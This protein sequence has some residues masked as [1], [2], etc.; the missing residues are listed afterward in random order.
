M[1]HRPRTLR[2]KSA[3]AWLMLAATSLLGAC[4]SSD[5]AFDPAVIPDGF[6]K[7]QC[8]SLDPSL[9]SL[10]W[11]SSLYLR[12]DEAAPSGYALQFGEAS[13]PANSG[14]VPL[15]PSLFAGLDGY[16]LGTPIIVGFGDLDVADLPSEWGGLESSIS[17]D[18][19]SILL[20][21]GEDG[22][23]PV[24]HFVERDGR[25]EPETAVAYLRPAE[26][27]AP[28]TRYIVAF[29]DLKDTTGAPIAP[30]EGFL[31][32]RDRVPSHDPGVASRRERFE[33]VF[34][35]LEAHG[36][37]R[38]ELVLAWDFTTGSL[39]RLQGRLDEALA[40]AL[41]DAPEGGALETVTVYPKEPGEPATATENPHIRYSIDATMTAPAVVSPPEPGGAFRVQLDGEGRVATSGA[42]TTKVLI[43]VPHA[44]TAGSPMGV[45]VY[46]HGMFGSEWEIYADH[47]ELLADQYGYVLVAVPMVGM[48]SDD[49]DGVTTAV[50]NMNHFTL[51]TDGLIQ[52]LLN[53]HMLARAVKSGAL[54]ELLAEVDP[55]IEID[56]AELHYF[57]GSQGGIYG[58][59]FLATSPDVH[60]G[61]LAVPGN[62]YATLLSRSVNFNVFFDVLKFAYP[63]DANVATLIAAA[64][65]LWD[66]SDPV[67]YLGR[68]L[69]GEGGFTPKQAL[70]LVAKGDYQVSVLTNEIAARTYP[71]LAVMKNYDAERLPFGLAET[72]YPHT[73]SGMVLFDFGNPWPTDRG[74]LPPEDG[75]TDPH[76]RIAEVEEAGDLLDH[77]LRTGTIIDVCGDA[78]CPPG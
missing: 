55:A 37:A 38:E 78:P 75:L 3:S 68:L 52:G 49:L 4:T 39:A 40:A 70:F 5:K 53:H 45:I 56:T 44:A 1:I 20:E 17:P 67:S 64:Q 28:S 15:D 33:D 43:Q 65:L 58:A 11:P 48:S 36:V 41:E 72:S 25:G 7:A 57:G 74:N 61:V 77:F 16:G 9:C 66:R 21:V 23:R 27:L 63:G 71:G 60:R 22:L 47:L 8:D 12:A 14:R 76:S 59:T 24:P 19:R 62:N 30:S 2:S 6:P 26:I 31:A 42:F 13:L 34:A 51:L 35:R 54:E 69:E 32:L 46:G 73:G 50:L 29:R 18:S 10:P